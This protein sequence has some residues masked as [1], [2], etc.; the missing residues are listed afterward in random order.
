MAGR[1][2]V[3]GA[4]SELTKSPSNVIFEVSNDVSMEC[5][6]DASAGINTIT[7][8][9]DGASVT[10]IPCTATDPSRLNVT[11][12]STNDC[13][14]LVLSNPTSG[15]QGPYH[16]SD[17]TGKTAEAVAVLIGTTSN[18]FLALPF[19]TPYR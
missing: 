6:T 8:R 1:A 2:R 14:I 4:L 16:C 15:I 10:T 19:T 9:Y 13:N 7:W 5:S 12:S 3:A 11:S 17:G 18:N